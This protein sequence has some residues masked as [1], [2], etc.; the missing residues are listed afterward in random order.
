MVSYAEFQPF[1]TCSQQSIKN[2]Q[3]WHQSLSPRPGVRGEWLMFRHF[4]NF[5]C[6][7]NPRP[8]AAFYSVERVGGGRSTDPTPPFPSLSALD[9]LRASRKK[10]E[11][12]ALNERK[13][14]VPN[15][16]VSGQSMTSEVT[17]RSNNRS[18]PPD[19][20]ILEML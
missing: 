12:V 20:I 19:T 15:F 17:V 3:E 16:K 8:C 9:G 2:R 4:Q 13:P 6:M 10:N 1:L 11:R 18:V 14:M 7:V 5:E